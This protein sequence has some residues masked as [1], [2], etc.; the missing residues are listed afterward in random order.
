MTTKIKI[1]IVGATGYTGV[2]LFA[3]AQQ[4]P[5]TQKSLPSPAEAKPVLRLP[6]TSPACA[7]F[8]TLHSKRPKRPDLTAAT[9]CSSP[10]PTAWP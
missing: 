9:L 1:G 6:T 4:P 5:P 7:A 3:S 2:E 10:H 8:T